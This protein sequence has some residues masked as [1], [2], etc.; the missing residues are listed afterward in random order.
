MECTNNRPLEGYSSFEVRREDAGHVLDSE[1]DWRLES[2]DLRRLVMA[3]DTADDAVCP[4]HSVIR[5]RVYLEDAVLEAVVDIEEEEIRAAEESSQS[6]HHL[7]LVGSGRNV[8]QALV[9]SPWSG[10][11]PR[12][13]QDA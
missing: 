8:H 12:S 4:R 6:Y 3:V 2:D 9:E 5:K 11:L 1:N 13:S 7:K 10:I